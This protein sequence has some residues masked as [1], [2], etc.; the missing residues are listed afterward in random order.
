MCPPAVLGAEVLRQYQAVAQLFYGVTDSVDN[1]SLPLQEVLQRR[2][3]K[4]TRNMH[5]KDI[6]TWKPCANVQKTVGKAGAS[7]NVILKKLLSQMAYLFL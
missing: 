4:T 3:A 6:F 2:A 1:A 7:F 5:E